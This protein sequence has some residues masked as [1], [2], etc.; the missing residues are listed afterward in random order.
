MTNIN[1]SK[2]RNWPVI[3]KLRKT[4][5]SLLAVHCKVMMRIMIKRRHFHSL[6]NYEK[7]T[8]ASSEGN[9]HSA[10]DSVPSV[11]N[12][13]Y[14]TATPVRLIFFCSRK[15]AVKKETTYL[16]SKQEARSVNEKINVCLAVEKR[17]ETI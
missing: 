11:N 3:F 13:L 10:G 2:V 1:K 15:P 17:G 12:S 5:S 4:S 14:I 16:S 9:R 7:I 6:N 8:K